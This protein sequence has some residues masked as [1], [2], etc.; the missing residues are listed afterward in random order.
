ML[1]QSFSIVARSDAP[2]MLPGSQIHSQEL[3]DDQGEVAGYIE[4]VCSRPECMQFHPNGWKQALWFLDGLDRVYG[5][6][7]FVD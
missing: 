1:L 6:M 3:M 5:S 2:V 7:S 4:M